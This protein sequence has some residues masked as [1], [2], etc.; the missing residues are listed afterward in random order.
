VKKRENHMDLETCCV[1]FDVQPAAQ[2][3]AR[4]KCSEMRDP[5]EPRTTVIHEH[6]LTNVSFEESAHSF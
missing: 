3:A 4:S 5:P 2:P 6:D 1:L